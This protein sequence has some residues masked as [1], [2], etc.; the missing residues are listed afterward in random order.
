MITTY[1]GHNL[2]TVMDELKIPKGH[3]L[4]SIHAY[5]PY[6][7]CQKKD[8]SS[9]WNPENPQ[10]TEEIKRA[11]SQMNQIFIQNG[12]P[13]ILTE[14][15]CVDKDNPD[16]RKAWLQYFMTMAKENGIRCIWW[17]NGSTFQLLDREQNS[18]KYPQLVECLTSEEFQ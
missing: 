16:D 1:A 9:E 4:V 13:V 18:W 3:I 12:V 2:E 5:L 6:I 17:D 10:D 7:F 15:G 11:L 8:G 14:F